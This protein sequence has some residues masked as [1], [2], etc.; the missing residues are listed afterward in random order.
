M[1]R[2]FTLAI[3][4]HLALPDSSAQTKNSNLLVVI[5]DSL[6]GY[7]VD[8]DR[9]REFIGN[10][11][12]THGEVRITCNNAIQNLTRNEVELIGNVII[13]QDSITLR[14]E[15]GKYYGRTKTAYSKDEIDLTNGNMNLK[16][17]IG[18]Y[19]SEDK[20]AQFI[21]NVI[22]KDSASTLIAD[23]LNYLSEINK[24]VAVGN[25]VVRDSGSSSLVADSLI[26]FRDE[27]LVNAFGRIEV[28]DTE[29][30]VSIFG[31][32]LLSD[33]SKKYRLI[34]GNPLFMQVDTLDSGKLDTLFISSRIMEQRT[35]SL[36]MFIAKDSVKI[37]RGDF[38]SSNSHTILY[39]DENKIFTYRPEGDEYPPVLW[40]NNSQLSGDS[41][42]IYLNDS[43]LE[44]IDI[45]ENALIVS[46]VGEYE[47]RFDQISGD[48]LKML[49]SNDEL[50][51]VD[52][53]GN[54][55]SIYYYM[56][57]S[58]ANGL[59]KSSSENATMLFED[60]SVNDV[61]LYGSPV[62]E[63]HP[64]GVIQGKEKEFTIPTFLIRGE[65]PGIDLFLK[66]LPVKVFYNR[67]RD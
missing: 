51:R 36:D 25:V 14:T 22:L 38:S 57:D 64:E 63:Y 52:I 12:I 29:N 54:V 59:M 23:R 67:G 24:I 10:V 21:N 60:N 35:D 5:G 2:F 27:E 31:E 13:T 1:I 11:V 15:R 4:I 66:K 41:V 45:R 3:L 48:K 34:E 47:F 46:N 40:Y 50:S 43:K 26:N 20:R 6:V 19:Y 18:Y 33:A 7:V 39:K 16:A 53:T 30:N 44:S 65:R 62:S 32:E 28:R 42:F 61:R 49:F 37:R 9:V 56:A 17:S 58:V 55:L 8:A